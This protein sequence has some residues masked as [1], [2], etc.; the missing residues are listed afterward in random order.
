MENSNIV[1]FTPLLFHPIIMAKG[2]CYTHLVHRRRKKK[3]DKGSKREIKK[4]RKRDKRRA[5]VEAQTEVTKKERVHNVNETI[6]PPRHPRCTCEY[7]SI[8]IVKYRY[9]RGICS[10]LPRRHLRRDSPYK[11]ELRQFC[12]SLPFSLFPVA[13]FGKVVRGRNFDVT[14]IQ[15]PVPHP[16]STASSFEPASFLPFVPSPSFHHMNGP[17]K[18][19]IRVVIVTRKFER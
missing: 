1:L 15:C 2:N 7:F 19:K 14:G 6:S 5:V 10:P 4:E 12:S 16:T 13:D 11:T 8:C 3:Q 18:I 9:S 17:K